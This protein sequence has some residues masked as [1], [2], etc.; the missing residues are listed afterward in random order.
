MN[1]EINI[2]LTDGRNIKVT[3]YPEYAPISVENFLNL[4]DKKYFDGVIF[5]RVIENFMIQT[6]G[7]YI[8]GNILKEKEGAKSIKGEFIKN[9][10]NNPIKHHKGTISMARTNDPNSASSQFF[11]CSVD[12]PHLDGQYAAFGKASDD[13]SIKVIE[14]ISTVKT[15]MLSP[16]FQNFP[17]EPI[18]IKTIVKL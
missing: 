2:I 3:L 4:V 13:E 11:L 17:Y 5:H 18:I 16:M 12:T 8:D 6:G 7:Y 10:V 1:P 9:G 14:D 15:G